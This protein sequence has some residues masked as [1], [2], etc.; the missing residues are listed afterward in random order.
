[1]TRDLER[2]KKKVEHLNGTAPCVVSAEL[3]DLSLLFPSVASVGLLF[4]DGVEQKKGR[5]EI[6][7][8][9]WSL[10]LIWCF[11]F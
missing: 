11:L 2:V 5:E 1:M 8:F 6:T 7:S 9:W 3:L 4:Y 10:T